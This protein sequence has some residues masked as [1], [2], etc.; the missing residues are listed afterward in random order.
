[1]TIVAD[2][3][4]SVVRNRKRHQG[5]L[6][7]THES[8]VE[9]NILDSFSMLSNILKASIFALLCRLLIDLALYTA[10]NRLDGRCDYTNLHNRDWYLKL[11]LR[12]K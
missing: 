8:T 3:R 7:D 1:M 6:F 12:K 4:S 2:Y 5:F 10:A 11:P 9:T